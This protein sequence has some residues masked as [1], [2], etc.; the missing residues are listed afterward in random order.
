MITFRHILWKELRD[1]WRQPGAG[2]ALIG[3]AALLA[4]ALFSGLPRY[5]AGE[6]GKAAA[7]RSVREQWI[8]QGARHPHSA[9]HF[10]IL[11]F[12]P[13]ESTA[14][15]EPGVSSFIGQMLPLQT[16][17]RAFPEWP[18]AEDLTSAVRMSL[19]S[20][21]QLALALVPL[22]VVLAGFRAISGEREGG[23]LGLLLASGVSPWAILAGKTA[24]LALVGAL[25]IAV[26][27]ALEIAALLLSGGAVPVGRLFGLEC[28]HA[29]YTLIWV[30][31]TIGVSA[32]VRSSQTTLSILLA[33]WLANS[34][35]LPRVAA[36][37]GRLAVPGPSTEEFRAAIQHDITYR[38]DGRP[39]VN[40]WSKG[41]I[42][43][44]L[45]KYG[46]ERIEDL[47][48]GYAGVMLKGSDAHYEEVFERHFDR[49][50]AIH[51][52][53]E[54]W[55]HALS[56][57]GPMIAARSLGQAFAGTDLVHAQH[58]SDAAE[59]YRRSFVE[60]TND[61]IEKRTTG[62]GWN[63]RLDR[64]YWESIPAFVYRPPDAWQAVRQHALSTAVLAGWMALATGWCV[65]GGRRLLVI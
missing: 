51:R 38:P 34:F 8:T 57:V 26:K 1:V 64:T 9:A 61:V 45:E 3:L 39:W 55:Q 62:T 25:A 46:V 52:R 20:P 21:A 15:V 18:P 28:V 56:L 47:P 10:G 7:A 31:A 41:L 24:A 22:L 65:R 5:R 16:H 35:V 32:R 36:S 19:L 4:L 27:A 43:Q 2:A 11:A 17:M 48:I 59:R 33:L 40:D 63:L 54:A 50:H 60:A 29:V 42:V 49:L 44:T 30:F 14:L 12:R 23:N 6:A 53:Q 13:L 37:V 58:F